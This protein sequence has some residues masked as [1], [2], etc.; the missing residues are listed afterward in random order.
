MIYFVE[1]PWENTR[2]KYSKDQRIN[3]TEINQ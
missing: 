3:S 1:N 2:K